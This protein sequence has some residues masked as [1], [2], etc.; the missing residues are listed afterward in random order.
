MIPKDYETH[1]SGEN[2]Y[3]YLVH[4]EI[5]EGRCIVNIDW[6]GI[7]RRIW[8]KIVNYHREIFAEMFEQYIGVHLKV[9]DK[10]GGRWKYFVFLLERMK[11][12]RSHIAVPFLLAELAFWL[13]FIIHMMNF[14][15]VAKY[16]G[17]FIPEGAWWFII[18]LWFAA[19]E[20]LWSRP[21]RNWHW[22]HEAYY[23]ALYRYGPDSSRSMLATI[24]IRIIKGSFMMG[25]L[26]V[27]MYGTDIRLG[28]IFWETV[29]KLWPLG[30]LTAALYVFQ[31]VYGYLTFGSTWDREKKLTLLAV[32]ISII[33]AYYAQFKI[34]VPID[35]PAIHIPWSWNSQPVTAFDPKQAVLGFLVAIALVVILGGIAW[36][37][38]KIWTALEDDTNLDV[39]N[40]VALNIWWVTPLIYFALLI[41]IVSFRWYHEIYIPDRMAAIAAAALQREVEPLEPTALPLPTGTV[42]NQA[43][44]PTFTPFV[45]PTESFTA[46]PA[47]TATVSPES[48]FTSTMTLPVPSETIT[49]SAT[50]APTTPQAAVTQDMNLPEP[51]SADALVKNCL[52]AHQGADYLL[53]ADPDKAYCIQGLTPYSAAGARYKINDKDYIFIF[54]VADNAARYYLSGDIPDTAVCTVNGVTFNG[55]TYNYVNVTNENT[56]SRVS[57]TF[58]GMTITA[59][60]WSLK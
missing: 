24:I 51:V 53:S 60:G 2:N 48:T 33:G 3:A 13:A 36:L 52:G 44:I 26:Y 54:V 9:T 10:F 34:F 57:C 22:R 58:D 8:Q 12:V 45:S 49:P 14:G 20:I 37:L 18:P 39:I 40:D 15:S 43:M 7:G 35:L 17:Q 47:F 19:L 6:K 31:A 38:N 59:T 46:T 27:V 50:V 1:T 56:N 29:I 25:Y 30:A 55:G 41:S 11:V 42:T 23:F 28:A 4:D 32:V 5:A 16:I 21:Y